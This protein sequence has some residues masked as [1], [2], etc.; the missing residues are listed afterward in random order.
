M[1]PQQTAELKF[2]QDLFRIQFK[3]DKAA[4]LEFRRRDLESTAGPMM[5]ML[6]METGRG[7]DLGCGVVSKLRFLER[8]V[9]IAAVDPLLLEYDN[10][11]MHRWPNC[12]YS[13]SDGEHL[14]Y[15]LGS[16]D[17]VWCV[18]VIDHT[19]DSRR[20]ASEIYRVLKPG[21]RLY[22][23]VNFDPE[24]QAPHHELWDESV[25]ADRLRYFVPLARWDI[26]WSEHQKFVHRGVYWRPNGRLGIW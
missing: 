5:D 10:I 16:F 26:W 15:A 19:P 18:N 25:V 6:K 11:F 23:Y 8:P 13:E 17:F 22:F 2:W 20:M 12:E 9:S 1:S 24:L 7:L 21:G 4:Y 3:S 14:P